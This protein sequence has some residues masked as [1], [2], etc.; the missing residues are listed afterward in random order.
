MQVLFKVEMP[1]GVIVDFGIIQSDQ[2]SIPS[3][4]VR[5]GVIKMAQV[6]GLIDFFKGLE[7][8]VQEI[9]MNIELSSDAKQ[10]TQGVSKSE[11]VEEEV[12]L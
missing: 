4:K 1:N 8:V 5:N 12:K 2:G 10:G 3:F 7:R 6:V 9:F 11:K